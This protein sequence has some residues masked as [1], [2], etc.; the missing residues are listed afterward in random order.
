[1]KR[2]SLGDPRHQRGRD[3][4]EE[5]S[6]QAGD[7]GKITT[8]AAAQSEETE[9]ECRHRKE[10]CD[11]R[12]CEHEAGQVEILRCPTFPHELFAFLLCKTIR[13]TR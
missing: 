5:Q 13:L 2:L 6:N 4:L 11:E 7:T 10:K 3:C 9:E 8:N 12:E 1:M